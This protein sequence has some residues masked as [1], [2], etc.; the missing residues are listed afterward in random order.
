MK[1]NCVEFEMNNYP[2]NN[3]A[4]PACLA[5]FQIGNDAELR[6]RNVCC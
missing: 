3:R 5:H 2:Q 4:I 1:G 6:Q